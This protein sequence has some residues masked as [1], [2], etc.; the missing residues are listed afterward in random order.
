MN[1]GE[2]EDIVAYNDILEYITLDTTSEEPFW[3]FKR[4][5]AHQG[6]L[7]STHAD[8]KGSRYN[9]M[10]EWETG[11]PQQNP[12]LLAVD[13]PIV[14]ALYAKENGLLNTEGWKQ[15]KSI[16]KCERNYSV[17]LIKLS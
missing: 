11:R 12:C 10:V 16:A 13:A 15:F 1:D 14:C 6:L 5:I 8:Y 2:Y 4:I 17:W 7:T 3:K 9:V